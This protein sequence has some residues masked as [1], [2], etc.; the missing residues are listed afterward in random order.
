[1]GPISAGQLA[2]VPI[3]G[4]AAAPLSGPPDDVP[5]E[6]RGQAQGRL[7]LYQ[8]TR[9]AHRRLLTALLVVA[10]PA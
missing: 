3:A 6:A 2:V 1:M 5:L 7:L 8:T 9:N 4:V 10:G